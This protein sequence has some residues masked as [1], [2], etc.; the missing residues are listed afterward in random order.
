MAVLGGIAVYKGIE[1]VF[2]GAGILGLPLVLAGLA[3][4]VVRTRWAWSG[5][6]LASLVAALSPL[7]KNHL[8][9]LFWVALACALF[10]EPAQRRFVLRAQLSIMYAF[11]ALSKLWP[12]W[13]EGDVLLRD[14]WIAPLLPTAVVLLVA[15]AAILVEAVLAVGVWR[16]GR[17]WLWIVVALHASFVAFIW[18]DA[19]ES[20]RL[21]VFG[22][23]VVS[24]FSHARAGAHGG[25]AGFPG[26]QGGDGTG[27]R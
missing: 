24:V 25:Q 4:R 10:P 3:T 8:V 11:A 5:I 22:I 12:D 15:W 16:P 23:M 9:L 14:T 6:A 27:R 19:L 21:V 1:A 17:H 26:G 13:L 7:Y 20:V 2:L 18:V